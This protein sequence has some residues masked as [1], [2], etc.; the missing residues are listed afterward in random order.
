MRWAGAILLWLACLAI[1]PEARAC[2]TAPADGVY[3]DVVAEDALI[4][5]DDV[6]RIQHFVRRADFRARSPR[7]GA[8]DKGFGFLVPTPT[9]PEL[10]DAPDE[11][12]ARLEAEVRPPREE[13]HRYE[14]LWSLC[15]STM[16]A[17]MDKAVASNDEGA[18]VRV[19][20]AQRVAGYDAVILEAND[21]DALAAWLTDNGYHLREALSGWL[22]RYVKNAWII[23]AFKIAPSDE[24]ATEMASSSVR[25]SFA[26][27][28][29]FF[30]Y[31]EPLDQEGGGGGRALRVFFVGPWRARGEIGD[32][33]PWP[34]EL[35]YG[36]KL[37]DAPALLAGVL[38]ERAIPKA[39]WLS[40][41]LDAS[42]P[43]PGSDEL[44][45]TRDAEQQEKELPPVVR[46]D[47]TTVPVFVD[48]LVFLA[49]LGC[50]GVRLFRRRA[51][52]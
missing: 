19:I 48:L 32:G 35:V 9:K 39:A 14:V 8:T 2:A 21:A 5:W 11:V 30:P 23:T 4:V 25:M 52:G 22:E 34:G 13:R 1:G 26:T 47:V 36:K 28:R 49:L 40:Y 43:R 42:S 38:E 27:E 51:T 3:V 24:D 17:N 37:G 15:G 7:A 18:S 33:T 45:F 50:G 41:H 10:A 29:P 16:R 44:F 12:F 6:R 20:G 46:Y 31:R